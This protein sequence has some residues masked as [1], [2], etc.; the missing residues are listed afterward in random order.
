MLGVTKTANE[1]LNEVS[2]YDKQNSLHKSWI[3]GNPT[4]IQFNVKLISY[5]RIK[6]SG[7]DEQ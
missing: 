5:F 2:I 4:D 1:F 6:Q 3:W 7:K